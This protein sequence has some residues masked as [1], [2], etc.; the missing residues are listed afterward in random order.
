[1]P[2][3]L[4]AD[5]YFTMIKE[6]HKKYLEHNM[7]SHL[8][9]AGGGN[10]ELIEKYTENLAF[11]H[12]K[13]KRYLDEAIQQ[14]STSAKIGHGALAALIGA[15]TGGLAYLAMNNNFS[16]IAFLNPLAGASTLIAGAFSAALG[17]GVTTLAYKTWQASVENQPGVDLADFQRMMNDAGFTNEQ[18]AQ[19]SEELV[20]LFHFR[21]CVLLGLADNGGVNMR[22]EFKK[23]YPADYTDEALNAAIEVYFLTQLN[24]LFNNAFQDIYQIHEQEIQEDKNENPILRWIKSYF[25]NPQERHKFTQQMQIEFMEQC[26]N[27][28]SKEMSEPS[29]FAKYPSAVASIGGLIAGAAVLGL[30][31]V[32][33]GGPITLGIAS[34]ALVVACLTAVP[35]YFS[36]NNIDSLKFTRSAENRSAIKNTIENISKEVERLNR[37]IQ[38][39]VETRPEDIAQAGKFKAQGSEKGWVDY[40]LNRNTEVAMGAGTAW[41]RDYASRYRHSKAIE[42]DLQN[43]QKDIINKAVDQTSTLQDALKQVQSSERAERIPAK[44]RDYIV[45]TKAYLSKADNQEFIKSFGLVAKIKQQVLEVVAIVPA[46]G[47]IPPDL[48]VFY[49]SPIEEGGLGGLAQDL[50]QVGKMASVVED[51]VAPDKNHPYSLM[52]AAAQRFDDALHKMEKEFIL[53]GDT[54]YR[55]MLGLPIESQSERVENKITSANIEDYLNTSFDFLYSL[56]K[57]SKIDPSANLDTP[58][59]NSNEFILYRTLLIKQLANLY[60]WNSQVDIEIRSKIEKF[61]QKKLQLD[62]KTVLDNAL[63]QMLFIESNK[64][65]P[66]IENPLNVS[67]SV[68]QLGYVAD[69]IRVDLAYASK[70]ITPK[71]LIE[72]EASSFLSSKAKKTIFSHNNSSDELRVMRNPKYAELIKQ[73]IETTHEFISAMSE[74]NGLVKSG[75]LTSYLYSVLREVQALKVQISTYEQLQL[76]SGRE[77]FEPFIH[78]KALLQ[79]Y[80]NELNV[81]LFNKPPVNMLNSFLNLSEFGK[82]SIDLS[83]LVNDFDFLEGSLALSK[84]TPKQ[85]DKGLSSTWVSIEITDN[86]QEALLPPSMETNIAM[87]LSEKVNVQT[88]DTNGL[89]SS[90]WVIMSNSVVL[91]KEATDGVEVSSEKQLDNFI[92]SLGAYIE[93]VASEQD[94]HYTSFFAGYSKGAKIKSAN[95]LHTALNDLREGNFVDTT[96]L[97]DKIYT[98]GRLNDCIQNNLKQLGCPSLN[99]LFEQQVSQCQFNSSPR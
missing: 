99:H 30:A 62:P 81:I 27:Y 8:E 12:G 72:L 21:E 5:T 49:T 83:S 33:I 80:E 68:A 54:Q 16:P 18:Y 31:M 46:G 94:N 67:L 4:Y 1:M 74:N 96:F 43:E 23:E 56:N 48:I 70:P 85:S 86:L 2:K 35:I 32:I 44:L 7:V 60:D 61:V 22:V 92:A 52:L 14:L 59:N 47:Y 82:N 40:I 98:D 87:E 28:L 37:L 73:T 26:L 75:A 84:D 34:I 3:R 41:V 9:A 88:L 63:S 91:P 25:Q 78:A 13:K 55:A 65:G 77:P 24:K 89:S 36:I 29:F 64:G 20:R 93:A 66:R 6:N 58:F 97:A 11:Y 95:R 51:D 79:E 39:V 50:S 71:M 38:E 53:L 45:N 69:A 57:S 90:E 76:K 19:L 17:V 42:I 15:G 10:P